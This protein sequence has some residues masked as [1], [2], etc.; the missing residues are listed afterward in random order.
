MVR[1]WGALGRG[2]TAVYA[3]VWSEAG[4][5]GCRGVRGGLSPRVEDDVRAV[6]D[7]ACDEA[8]LRS[9]AAPAG[10]R[11]SFFYAGRGVAIGVA[12]DPARFGLLVESGSTS[13]VILP[14]EARTSS[15]AWRKAARLLQRQH[16]AQ[17]GGQVRARLFAARTVELNAEEV[18]ACRER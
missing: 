11:V 6:L 10:A 7:A 8:M 5:E 16:L 9:S 17:S 12:Y 13:A 2:A 14:G 18:A 15:Y 1:D 3:T 4:V